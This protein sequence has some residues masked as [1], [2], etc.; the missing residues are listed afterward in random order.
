MAIQESSI[1]M[2][3]F[4]EVNL[5]KYS[6]S[7]GGLDMFYHPEGALEFWDGILKMIPCEVKVL[8]LCS[9]GFDS[10]ALVD[11]NHEHLFS[12]GIGIDTEDLFS[13]SK[14]VIIMSFKSLIDRS[15]HRP[16]LIKGHWWEE[17]R[18]IVKDEGARVNVVG[19]HD[20]GDG[21]EANCFH[22]SECQ[23]LYS[24]RTSEALAKSDSESH[25]FSLAG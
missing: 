21:V 18:S 17:W 5:P 22:C 10:K 16:D 12:N 8:N 13:C 23:S 6:M 9:D 14:S 20:G 24:R 1:V 4:G 3:N 11:I 19:R 15:F 7:G 2:A 25:M